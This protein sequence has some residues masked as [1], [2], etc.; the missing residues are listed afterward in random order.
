VKKT[1]YWADLAERIVRT[2]IQAALAVVTTDLVGVTDL[3]SGKALL[4]AA[5]AAGLSAVVGLVARQFGDPD[6]ASFA[7]RGDK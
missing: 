6:T 1:D 4:I 5:A 3:N 2:F 7:T